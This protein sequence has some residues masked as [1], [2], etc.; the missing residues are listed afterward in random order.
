MVD[1]DPFRPYEHSRLFTAELCG[2]T[3][4]TVK[5]ER[6]DRPAHVPKFLPY[7]QLKRTRIRYLHADPADLRYRT[8]YRS[9]GSFSDKDLRNAFVNNNIAHDLTFQLLP[10]KGAEEIPVRKVILSAVGKG[11]ALH[12]EFSEDV[13]LAV[14]RIYGEHFPSCVGKSSP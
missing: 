14:I 12:R 6:S 8:E 2:E 7:F 10:H 11:K 4:N 13:L 9:C 1:L 3:D 5:P